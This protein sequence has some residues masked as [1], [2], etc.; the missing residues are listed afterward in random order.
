MKKAAAYLKQRGKEDAIF[1]FDT[2]SATVELAAQA[3][4]VE[5]CRIAKSLTFEKDD[6]CV[7]DRCCRKPAD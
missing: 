3:L 5:A 1:V 2:S 7:L 6:G 4:G